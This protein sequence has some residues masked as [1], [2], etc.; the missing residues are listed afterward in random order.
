M[1]SERYT[2]HEGPDGSRQMRSWPRPRG[3]RRPSAQS[4]HGLH[5]GRSRPPRPAR[6]PPWLAGDD[7][8]AGGPVLRTVQRGRVRRRQVDLPHQPARQQRGALLPARGR[9]RPPRCC[10]SCTRRPSGPRSRSSATCSAVR[11]DLLEHRRRRGHRPRAGYRWP[12]ARRRRPRGRLRR[13]GDPRHRRLG[14]RRHRHLDRQACGLHRR[15]RHRPPT[16]RSPWGSTWGPTASS[17]STTPATWGCG[18]PGSA[19]R[20][21]RPSSTPTS[22]APRRTSRRRSCTGRTSRDLR[23]GGSSRSTATPCA[24]STTTSRAPPPW[25]WRASSPE[26]ACRGA[27][28]STSRSSSSARARPGSASLTSSRSP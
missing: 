18:A 26:C 12:R 17:C 14:R 16:G 10:R 3:A 11:G 19:G 4:R 20:R 8:P 1:E 28:W 9:A 5:H 7:G 25:A 23:H 21:T 24:P 13:R 22:P 2:V 15:G 27:G 6:A